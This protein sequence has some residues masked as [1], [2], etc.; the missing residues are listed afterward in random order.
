M[1]K[2]LEPYGD[3]H[4]EMPLQA[5]SGISKDKNQVLYLLKLGVAFDS[6]EQLVHVGRGNC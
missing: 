3:Q 4:F 5:K 6:L 2:K 1:I